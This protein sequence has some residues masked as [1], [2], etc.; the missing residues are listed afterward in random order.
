MTCQK[1]P[2]PW[3]DGAWLGAE[4]DEDLRKRPKIEL[5]SEK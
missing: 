2:N 5:I 3:R 1:K 4:E